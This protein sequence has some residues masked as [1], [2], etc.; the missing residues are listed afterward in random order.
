MGLA[1]R[2]D[3][4]M[5]V[6]WI[7]ICLDSECAEHEGFFSENNLEVGYLVEVM[8][9]EMGIDVFPLYSEFVDKIACLATEFFPGTEN[10]GDMYLKLPLR[11]IDTSKLEAIN[12][13]W[14]ADEILSHWV[15][16][17]SACTAENN[18]LGYEKVLDSGVYMILAN[19]DQLIQKI[20]TQKGTLFTQTLSHESMLSY[21]KSA[22]NEL[23]LF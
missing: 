16:K 9:G 7:E 13:K 18:P 3:D 20:L 2:V 8:N 22:E 6:E 4:P 14:M 12:R 10:I 23:K 1:K 15:K 21:L 11:K 19:L 5:L 17:I